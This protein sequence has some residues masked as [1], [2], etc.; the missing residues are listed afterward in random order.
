MDTVFTVVATIVVVVVLAAAA[1][2]FVV[3]P[4]VVPWRHV[5]H[6]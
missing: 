5:H 2:A 4:L 3:A 6:Q 1:W